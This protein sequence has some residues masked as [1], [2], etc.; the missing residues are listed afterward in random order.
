MSPA[1]AIDSERAPTTAMAAALAALL[2]AGVVGLAFA[3]GGYFA[4][5][6]GIAVAIAAAALAVAVLVAPSLVLR[7]SAPLVLAVGAIALFALWALLSARWSH[8]PARALMEADRALLYALGVALAGLAGT[9]ARVRRAAQAALVAALT[10]ASIGGLITRV[11]P[12]LWP[13]PAGMEADRLSYPVGYWNAAGMIGALA[14]IGCLHLAAD[15]GRRRAVRTVAAAAVPLVAATVVLTF[16]RGAIAAGV[17][18]VVVALVLARTPGTAAALLATVPTS[19]VAVGVVLHS[20]ALAAATPDPGLGPA[21]ALAACAVAAGATQA[22]LHGWRTRVVVAPR[23]ARGL[24]VGAVVVAVGGAVATGAAGA[25]IERAGDLT[26]SSHVVETGDERARLTQLSDNGRIDA[27]RVSLDAFADA[28]LN[29][30][31][32][33]TFALDWARDRPGIQELTDGHSLLLEALGELGLVGAGLLIAAIGALAWGAIRA[34]RSPARPAAAL[35]LAVLAA[36]VL[37]ACMDWDWEMPALTL[38]ALAI[39]ALVANARGTWS[40]GAR[41]AG[42]VPR[43]IAVAALACLALVGV[44]LA[45]SQHDVDTAVAAVHANRCPDAVRAADAAMRVGDQRPEPHQVLA[46]C[47]V[48]DGDTAAATREI[49]RAIALDPGDWRLV[50]D[51][52]VIR[53]LDG[54]DPRPTMRQARRM[55]PRSWLLRIAQRELNGATPAAWKTAALRADL[56]L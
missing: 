45:L 12:D 1:V 22:A 21:L 36:W 6:T 41:S 25:V 28:P 44:G 4:G 40:T 47:A 42:W 34:L 31:G 17:V 52:A 26:R 5:T 56:L 23:L 33:G 24:A 35:G 9:L 50:Y 51:L 55:N 38:P 19:A 14:A 49:Q 39:V 46:I 15:G 32:A 10:I 3:S 53:A 8:A 43:S 13:T 29:G 11:L 54:R 20:D 18:G 48:H 2:S 30:S 37:H 27:W 7:W 16:S